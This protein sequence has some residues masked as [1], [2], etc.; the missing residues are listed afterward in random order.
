M[1]FSSTQIKTEEIYLEFI[2]Y[3]LKY[4]KLLNENICSDLATKGYLKCLKYLLS[5]DKEY[6]FREDQKMHA[7]DICIKATESGRLE[8]LKY[9]I[10]NSLFHP[11]MINNCI[12]TETA[13]LKGQLECLKYLYE[14]DFHINEKCAT[15]SI[16]SDKLDC[17]QYIYINKKNIFNWKM[18]YEVA[19][20]SFSKNC[21]NFLE[22]KLGLE[23]TTELKYDIF[24][25]HILNLNGFADNF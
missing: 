13:S 9:A 8:F 22:E 24:S 1:E 2:K 7:N 17:L 4:N 11:S 14:S 25:G 16:M 6:K 15:N 10:E 23:K 12:L 18:C 5:D 19:K 21:V 20:Y 3:S